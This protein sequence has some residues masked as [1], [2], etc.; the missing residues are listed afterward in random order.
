MAKGTDGSNI[1]DSLQNQCRLE[2]DDEANL[3]RTPHIKCLEDVNLITLIYLFTVSGAQFHTWDI[4]YGI[5]FNHSRFDKMSLISRC[6]MSRLRVEP[7]TTY[8]L[9]H[10]MSCHR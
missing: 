2:S 4:F 5:Y 1:S 6:R 8:F 9:C 10:P 7:I 3:V